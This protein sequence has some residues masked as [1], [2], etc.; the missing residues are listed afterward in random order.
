MLVCSSMLTLLQALL[1]DVAL[2][3]VLDALPPPPS[4]YSAWRQLAV[5][6]MVCRQVVSVGNHII[7]TINNAY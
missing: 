6:G 4:S 5:E 1:L 7:N 2:V 3:V